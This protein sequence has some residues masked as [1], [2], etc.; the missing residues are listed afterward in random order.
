MNDAENIE[1]KQADHQQGDP[2]DH[3]GPFRPCGS[4]CGCCRDPMHLERF[5]SVL[6]LLLYFHC[7]A[8]NFRVLILRASSKLF[9]RWLS[10]M[11]L[12]LLYPTATSTLDAVESSSRK[13]ISL[14]STHFAWEYIPVPGDYASQFYNDSIIP[15]YQMP[16]FPKPGTEATVSHSNIWVAIDFPV[17]TVKRTISYNTVVS[18]LCTTKSKRFKR[19]NCRDKLVLTGCSLILRNHLYI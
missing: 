3:R 16:S 8:V 13:I 7:G 4:C 11:I 12:S 15:N 1:R 6:A 17:R 10:S 14:A 9:T 2:A 19:R 5:G 18:G